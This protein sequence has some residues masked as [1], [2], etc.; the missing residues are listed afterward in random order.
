MESMTDGMAELLKKDSNKQKYHSVDL[1][2]VEDA[3]QIGRQ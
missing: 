3:N 2:R 1:L